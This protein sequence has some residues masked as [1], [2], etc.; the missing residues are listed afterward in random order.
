MYRGAAE[1]MNIFN[2]Y[3]HY[4]TSIS[5]YSIDNTAVIWYNL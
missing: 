5:L 2:C 4:Y 1:I 3:Y